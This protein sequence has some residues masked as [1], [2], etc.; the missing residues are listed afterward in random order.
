MSDRKFFFCFW[1]LG[2][3]YMLLIL[4]CAAPAIKWAPRPGLAGGE[5]DKD[6]YECRREN[7]LVHQG[8][9]YVPTY[10]GGFSSGFAQGMAM[11][12]AQSGT[13]VDEDQAILCMRARGWSEAQQ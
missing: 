13:M 4:G 10:G 11:R 3:M 2:I 6:A 7:T 1:F 9:P 5:F 12:N 8:V